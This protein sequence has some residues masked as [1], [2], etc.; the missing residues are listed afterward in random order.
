[1]TT[2]PRTPLATTA[3][4]LR[5]HPAWRTYLAISVRLGRITVQ[6]GQRQLRNRLLDNAFRFEGVLLRATGLTF[7]Q[8]TAAANADGT[9]LMNAIRRTYRGDA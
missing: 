9:A 3:D 2:E 5:G 6:E 1:M 4:R 8:I 7:C